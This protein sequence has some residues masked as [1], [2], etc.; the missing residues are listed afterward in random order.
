M[1]FR[2]YGLSEGQAE[3]QGMKS[4]AQL[5]FDYL[6]S[7]S[8]I[9]PSKVVLFGQSIGGAVAIHLASENQDKVIV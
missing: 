7:H 5:F 1:I 9:N 8:E 3:E 2:G 6:I 4:D